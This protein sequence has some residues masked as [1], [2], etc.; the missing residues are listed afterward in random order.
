MRTGESREIPIG[1]I[2]PFKR[3]A[4]SLGVTVK[5]TS[6]GKL[7][8]TLTKV[9]GTPRAKRNGE[10]GWRPFI[11]KG[12]PLPPGAP[13]T[14]AETIGR[15]EVNDSLAYPREQAKAVQANVGYVERHQ[16]REFVFAKTRGETG[17]VWRIK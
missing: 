4:E 2:P 13:G 9:K 8:A 5:F 11:E 16:G 12:V 15:M 10:N 3:A 14:L 1:H 17:R 6:A 7:R